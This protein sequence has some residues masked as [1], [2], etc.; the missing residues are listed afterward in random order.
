MLPSHQ[1]NFGIAVAEALGS[2]LPVLI[3]DKVNIWHEVTDYRAG[4]VAADTLEGTRK[5]L[6]A[7]L[8]MTAAERQDMSER[9]RALFRE[10]FTVEAMADSLLEVVRQY[11]KKAETVS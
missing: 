4:L 8:T 7:W 9:A 3:S 1:E 5:L 10:R 6:T 11:G 2:G